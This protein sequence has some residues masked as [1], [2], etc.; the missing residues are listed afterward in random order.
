MNIDPKHSSAFI[1]VIEA[2]SFERA[3]RMLHIT[4]SAV[5]QRIRA[6]EAKIGAP[7][8][9]RGRPCRPTVN[10][11]HLLKYLRQ[12]SILDADLIGN[13]AALQNQRSSV[14][15]A[16]NSDSLGTWFFHA[17]P[18]IFIEELFTLDL[19]VED[20]D[21]TFSLLQSGMVIGCISTQS[22]PMRGCSV[23]ALGSMRYRLIA[24]QSFCDRWFQTGFTRSSA[25]K[26][27]VVAYSRRDTV[28]FH[29]LRE[30]LGLQTGSY[31]CHYVPGAHDHFAAVLH[32]IGYALV[33][34]LLFGGSAKLSSKGLV[35]LEPRH[36]VDI[37]LY[38]HA[39]DTQ[40]KIIATL[41]GRIVDTARQL[42]TQV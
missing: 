40:S 19:I 17:L 32:G 37:T 29:Y 24:S 34:E 26:A 42:L 23:S 2:G 14:S 21:R 5:T 22:T 12:I 31:V 25:R 28:Q 9:I 30:H 36:P 41:C 11:S 27:P 16:L 38:F 35:D 15:I 3:A 20:E 39:W 10:G 7:L 6:L 18:K 1:E 13:L 33:P 4:P 8:I